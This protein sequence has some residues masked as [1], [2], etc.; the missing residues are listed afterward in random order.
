MNDNLKFWLG[1]LVLLAGFG[2]TWTVAKRY[3]AHSAETEWEW[4]IHHPGL[5]RRERPVTLYQVPPAWIVAGGL[6]AE[7]QNNE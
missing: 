4:T 7:R 1:L 2:G 6:I 5:Q 3:P